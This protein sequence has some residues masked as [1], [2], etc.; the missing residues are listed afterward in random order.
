[1]IHWESSE[2]ETLAAINMSAQQ[3]AFQAN[4]FQFDLAPH[5]FQFIAPR[6]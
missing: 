5:E 2:G 3:R 4:D 6:G 1:V